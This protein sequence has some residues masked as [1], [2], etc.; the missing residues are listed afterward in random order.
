[1]WKA[2]K[3]ELDILFNPFKK[4]GI[5]FHWILGNHDTIPFGYSHKALV[6][7]DF[8]KTIKDS[9]KKIFLSHFPHLCWNGSHYGSWNLHGHIHRGD[10]THKKGFDQKSIEIGCQL[11]VNVEFHDWKPWSFDEVKDFMSV[12]NPN[13]DLCDRKPGADNDEQ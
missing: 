1:M 5:S 8:I 3:E 11:N 4:N 6:S 13:W 12:R 7:R 2:K 10:S 9:D